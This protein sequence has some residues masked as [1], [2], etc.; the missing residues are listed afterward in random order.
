MKSRMYLIFLALIMSF[1]F[2]PAWAQMNANS[3]QE[4]LLE[5]H[6]NGVVIDESTIGKLKVLCRERFPAS[7]PTEGYRKFDEK[8]MSKLDLW[9]SRRGNNDI[10]ATVYNGT[11]DMVLKQITLLLIPVKKD[12]VQDFFD[13]EEFHISVDVPPKGS[14]EFIIKAAET[15]MPDK[16]RWNI[17]KAIGY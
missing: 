6:R 17:V 1:I 3:Y 11:P 5:A 12:P 10:Q 2:V 16:F 9:T 8:R 7:A 13:A 14:E 15:G 4:C